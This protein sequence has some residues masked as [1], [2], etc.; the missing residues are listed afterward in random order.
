MKQ[1]LLSLLVLL[2][3]NSTHAQMYV[4]GDVNKDGKV[5][6]SDV[7]KL[8]DMLN[9]KDVIETPE[10]LVAGVWKSNDEDVIVL[11]ADGTT[12]YCGASSFVYKAND[13]VIYMFD[14][15]NVL[16][17]AFNVVDINLGYMVLKA[18]GQSDVKTYYNSYLWENPATKTEIVYKD[19][20]KY[21]DN[22]GIEYIDLGLSVCWASCNLGAKNP[23]E[24]GKYYSWGETKGYYIDNFE[25]AF[26]WPEYA[27]CSSYNYTIPYLKKYLKSDIPYYK[28]LTLEDVDDA[29]MVELKNGWRMPTIIE[30]E[31]LINKCYWEYTDNYKNTDVSGFIVFKQKDSADFCITHDSEQIYTLEDTYI[32]I[33][34]CGVADRRGVRGQGEY[35]CFWTKNL[36]ISDEKCAYTLS[37]N[38]S[39]I[40]E[41]G[42]NTR[43]FGLCIRPVIQYR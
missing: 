35:G 36:D 8:V 29:A 33:P 27:W 10:S 6:L 7:T 15:S 16:V 41:I 20:D 43:C 17:Q 23:Y 11:K 31:E 21:I 38:F 4:N 13:K 39:N 19:R 5:S 34:A 32:F 18:V 28:W 3:M 42:S 9:G 2:S 25:K 12:D 26:Q 30:V 22:N 40:P 1:L 24:Y 14:D 37:T